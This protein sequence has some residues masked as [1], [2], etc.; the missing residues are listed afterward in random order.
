MSHKQQL[1]AQIQWPYSNLPLIDPTTPHKARRWLAPGMPVQYF[2]AGQN[3]DD[4]SAN[5]KYIEGPG[6]HRYARMADDGWV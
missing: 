2:G 5:L 3:E 1:G 4:L 6:A